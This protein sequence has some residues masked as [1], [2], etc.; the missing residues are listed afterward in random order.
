MKARDCFTAVEKMVSPRMRTGFVVMLV[1]LLA[2]TVQFAAGA[3]IPNGTV[4]VSTG[5]GLVTEFDQDGNILGQLDTTTGS[6]YTTGSVFDSAGNFFVTDFTA[7]Q[8]T[9]FDPT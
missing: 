4:M 9:K 5:N 1:G 2:L 8:V 7:S 3:T 6:F